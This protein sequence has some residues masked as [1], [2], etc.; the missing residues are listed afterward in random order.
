MTDE[1]LKVGQG[2][3]CRN[4]DDEFRGMIAGVYDPGQGDFEYLVR[5]EDGTTSF[6]PRECLETR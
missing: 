4:G 5:H 1:Q 3:T 6:W 2:V